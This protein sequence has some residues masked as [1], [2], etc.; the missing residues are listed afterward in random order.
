MRLGE[1]RFGLKG[2]WFWA[3]LLEGEIFRVSTPASLCG[4]L[5]AVASYA[6]VG[7][8]VGCLVGWLSAFSGVGV[9]L[10]FAMFWPLLHRD[11]LSL[12]FS[13]C[14]F[15]FILVSFCPLLSSSLCAHSCLPCQRPPP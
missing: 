14:C 12:S 4:C 2:V 9:W 13:E 7:W 10:V 15:V 11:R 5:V 3:S 1:L 6:F 8:L